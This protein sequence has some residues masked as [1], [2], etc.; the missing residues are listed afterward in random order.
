M[1]MQRIVE[2][3]VTAITRNHRYRHSLLTAYS[4]I[5]GGMA[6]EQ[7]KGKIKERYPD[8]S[9]VYGAVSFFGRKMENPE[10]YPSADDLSVLCDHRIGQHLVARTEAKVRKSLG[11]RHVPK[12]RAAPYYKS[13]RQHGYD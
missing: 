11:V 3:W 4:D 8:A 5:V 10:E 1:D 12:K 2:G 7:A 13:F 9:D 6:W